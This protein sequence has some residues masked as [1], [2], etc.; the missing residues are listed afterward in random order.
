MNT[1][2]TS[3][4]NPN[5][6]KVWEQGESKGNRVKAKRNKGTRKQKQREG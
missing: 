2:H 5:R 3:K 6:E 4:Q 1:H